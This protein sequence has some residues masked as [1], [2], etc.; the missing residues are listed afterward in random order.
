MIY[1]LCLSF[2][3]I[4]CAGFMI[5][6]CVPLINYCLTHPCRSESVYKDEFSE[7]FLNVVCVSSHNRGEGPSMFFRLSTFS[8][9]S[10]TAIGESLLRGFLESKIPNLR[11][12]IRGNNKRSEVF[13]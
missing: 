5:L 8:T 3:L 9:N 1:P 13:D 4:V 2:H 7:T 12:E 6:L 10:P 11:L